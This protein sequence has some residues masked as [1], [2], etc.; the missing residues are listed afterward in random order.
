MVK[1]AVQFFAIIITAYFFIEF[2]PY[3]R[4]YPY[5]DD[6]I[7]TAP[8]QFT[9]LKDWISWLFEQ[10]VDHRIP[11]QKL[12]SYTVLRVFSFD[13]R[14]LVGCNYL[15]A[16][17]MTNGL[18]YVARTYR[19]YQSIGDA[20]IPFICLEYAAGFTQWAFQF[21]F[22]FSMVATSGFIYFCFKYFEAKNIIYLVF[23]CFAILASALCGMNGL[24]AA[25]WCTLSFLGWIVLTSSMSWNWSRTGIVALL[26][27]CLGVEAWIWLSWRPTDATGFEFNALEFF[28]FMVGLLPSS[29]LVY[30]FDEAWWKAA[31]IFVLLCLAIALFARDTLRKF[32]FGQ[33]VLMCGVGASLLIIASVSLGRAKAQGGWA[34][35]IVMHYGYLSILIP[36]MSWIVV[37]KGLPRVWS[38]MLGV[39]LFAVFAKTFFVNLD[40]RK[41]WVERAQQHQNEVMKALHESNDIEPVVERYTLDFTWSIE[42]PFKAAV[43][44]GIKILR[45]IHAKPYMYDPQNAEA[46]HSE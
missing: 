12:F 44:D 27:I 43:I 13:F 19:G 21:Q 7:F 38:A 23:G 18:L 22:L 8:I 17:L 4:P 35:I 6:W 41:A 2:L 31:L 40:W 9:S 1:I 39:L 33:F 14:Y 11:I 34:S 15:L 20:L 10:H 37:S 26:F 30:A 42:P 25:T 45:Q 24:I 29:M 36:I 5:A 28:K 16:L 32:N 46:S 3:F